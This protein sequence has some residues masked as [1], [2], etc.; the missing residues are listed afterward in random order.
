MNATKGAGAVALEA[1]DVLGGP[2]DRQLTFARLVLAM[3]VELL[4]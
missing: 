2:V 3:V 4:I 1:E